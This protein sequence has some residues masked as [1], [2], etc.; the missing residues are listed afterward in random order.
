MN[1][2]L[3]LLFTLGLFASPTFGQQASQAEAS[4]P[5]ICSAETDDMPGAPGNDNGK[6]DALPFDCATVAVLDYGCRNLQPAAMTAENSAP[7]IS[8]SE[9]PELTP[10]AEQPVAEP[11]DTPAAP[12]KMSFTLRANLLRWVTL[13]P[14]LGI[15]WRITPSVAV[16]VAASGA[17]NAWSWDDENYRYALWE[18]APE[19]RWYL[20]EK[21]RGYLGAMFK[22]GA[23][24]YKFSETGK[25]GDILG[26]GITGGYV[27]PLCKSLSMDFSIGVGYLKAD[28]EKY[29]IIQKGLR[30]R[31]S[32]E[33]KN[34]W[35]P[36][37]AGISLVWKLF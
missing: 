10:V 3:P 14:D 2:F 23:F 11:A 8:G 31:Q 5:V 20:G 33:T 25:Q 29:E 26:G 15:E 17:L 13:T 27:L 28:Y 16:T 6:T 22:M 18:V 36:V 30:V 35:G 12:R 19:V 9:T 4:E 7:A 34:W 37:N 24:N 1:K 21:K 32:P